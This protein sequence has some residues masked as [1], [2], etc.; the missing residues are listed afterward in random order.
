MSNAI[1][2]DLSQFNAVPSWTNLWAAV[3][4]VVH[5]TT[6]GETGLDADLDSRLDNLAGKDW[7]AYLVLIPGDS[8]TKQADHALDF[9]YDAKF[10]WVDWELAGAT[11][12]DAKACIARIED[13]RPDL[14]VVLYSWASWVIQDPGQDAAIADYGSNNGKDNGEPSVDCLFH[15]YTS[16]GTVAGINP[17]DR[18]HFNG[19]SAAFQ[20]WI[21]DNVSDDGTIALNAWTTLA[22]KL[23]MPTSGQGWASDVAVA[24]F[25]KLGV[26]GPEGPQGPPGEKGEKGDAAVLAPDTALTVT[27]VP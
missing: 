4:F 8:G 13:Q 27:Q 5:R 19:D 20:A 15:Q 17:V 14:P 2:V 23:G 22:K 10:V 12:A 16:K 26:P 24:V 25:E 9:M 3:D 11:L 18:D 7:G 6:I 1:G 21:G